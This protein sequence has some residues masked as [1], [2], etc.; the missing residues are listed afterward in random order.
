MSLLCQRL[1]TRIRIA[2]GR[3]ARP[4]WPAVLALG[5]WA[6]AAN[7][8]LAQGVPAPPPRLPAVLPPGGGPPGAPDL[9]PPRVAPDAATP[10]RQPGAAGGDGK[11][12]FEANPPNLAETGPVVPPLPEKIIDLAAALG[13]AEQINPTIGI[14]RQAIREAIAGQL[15]ANSLMLPILRAGTNYHLHN[16]ILQTSFG[17]MRSVDEQSLYFGGGARTLAAETVA[18]PMVQIFSEITDAIFE[19]L[20]ARQMVVNRQAN[21]AA[22]DNNIL[23]EVAGRYLDLVS[24]EA[25]Q[26]AL[27]ESENDL[28]RMEKRIA[29]QAATGL[30]RPGNA[31]RFQAAALL[32]HVEEQQAEERVAVASAELSRLLHLDPSIRLRSPA[33]GIGL[34][35]L[36]D[37]GYSL[38]QLLEFARRSRPELRAQSAMVALRTAQVREEKARPFLP[39][40]SLGFSAG[41]FG[42]S[43]NRT[44]LIPAGRSPAFDHFGGRTDLD[45]IIFWTLQN[46][47][48]GNIA[49]V[50]ERLAQRGI[51]QAELIRMA[52]VVGREVTQAY[53]VSLATR[54]Q[55]G[56][57]R[58]RLRIAEKGYALEITAIEE[59]LHLPLEAYDAMERLIR[60]RLDLIRALLDY[61]LAQFRLFV[62][63]GQNPMCA[64]PAPPVTPDS[65]P[66]IG[67]PQDEKEGAPA[68][69]GAAWSNQG[70]AG[71]RPTVQAPGQQPA[72]W[73][74]Q[75]EGQKMPPANPT[76]PAAPAPSAGRAE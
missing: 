71:P 12:L 30:A 36:V 13:L 48:A 35:E 40:V 2:C 15:R 66:E 38:P 55:V 22:V 72:V 24:A 49:L 51:A 14:A 59:R 18:F 54:R 7:L 58:Q 37:K 41:A 61:D 45:A 6:L 25:E 50:H 73:S 44:D 63:V 19:P 21:A 34:V 5:A 28:S 57:A 64:Q 65:A 16:G 17:Q 47:G 75:G 60:A 9:P 42:G 8:A 3:R 62:A 69:A 43:T 32:L 53:S 23:L 29:S 39:T 27:R 67:R 10:R 26:A 52:T 20:V 11:P 4:K 46:C 56:Y 76:P 33:G 70:E 1:V 31:N 74:A 68:A